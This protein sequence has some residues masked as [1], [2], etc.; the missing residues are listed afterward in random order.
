MEM[1]SHLLQTDKMH[2]LQP[3][4]EEG[5]LADCTA[6]APGQQVSQCRVVGQR[7][8]DQREPVS[9]LPQHKSG[10]QL[11]RSKHERRTMRRSQR[12]QTDEG[13]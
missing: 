6:A 12:C 7:P 4:G 10:N 2:T 8:V 3:G 5:A 11:L 9:V 1:S 13:C